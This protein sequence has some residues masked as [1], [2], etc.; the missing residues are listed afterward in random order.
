VA[1]KQK[2]IPSTARLYHGAALLL[3]TLWVGCLWSV[4]YVAVPVLFSTL[5]DKM[6]AGMLAGKM[7]SLTAYIGIGSACYLL[8]Y[9]AGKSGWHALRQPIFQVVAIMLLMT[10]VGEFVFQPLMA[11]LKAQAL[12]GDVMHSVFAGRFRLLH[13]IAEIMYLIQSLLG[14][15]LTLKT[16]RY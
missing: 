9:F 12:P 5:P 15:I 8:I 7:F 2:T 14:I 10:L 16:I 4:G 3:T 1:D 13:G 11:N 6:L